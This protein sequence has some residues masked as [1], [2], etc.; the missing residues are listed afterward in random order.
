MVELEKTEK[1][2]NDI[3]DYSYYILKRNNLDG[4]ELSEEEWEK[5]QELYKRCRVV[6]D[7]LDQIEA[8]VLDRDLSFVEVETVALRKGKN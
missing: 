1:L 8:K 5:L 4:K 6:R 2:L 7:E 3:A